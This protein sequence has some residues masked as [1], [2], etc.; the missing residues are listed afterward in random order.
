MT[1][2]KALKKAIRERMSETGESYT[3]ARRAV[4]AEHRAA[5]TT[6]VGADRIQRD[7]LSAQNDAQAVSP[8]STPDQV[9]RF[10]PLADSINTQM[11]SAQPLAEA[12]AR[13][14]ASITEPI[15]RA[16]MQNARVPVV[17][18]FQ[19]PD[20]AASVSEPIRRAMAEN[21]RVSVL[22]A[23]Q[24]QE[25]AA[26]VTEPIRRAMENT[27]VATESAR[28]LQELVNRSYL[29]TIAGRSN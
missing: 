4:L 7:D 17:P 1:E 9:V 16:V 21:V 15:R 10:Q 25:L 27:R 6:E 19:F 22:P 26:S 12:Y 29:G 13:L 2:N 28:Q 5:P 20:L 23:L 14:A 11:R 8:Q 24:L 3:E 18:A